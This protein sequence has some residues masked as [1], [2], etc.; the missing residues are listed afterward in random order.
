MRG[1]RRR[2]SASAPTSPIFRAGWKDSP[3]S[4]ETETWTASFVPQ[5]TYT[6]TT[7]SSKRVPS[8]CVVV[9][10]TATCG[11]RAPAGVSS[12]TIRGPSPARSTVRSRGII[13]DPGY[14]VES[15]S[16]P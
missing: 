10:E 11:W 9:R 7:V 5:T 3:P 2:P 15:P 13:A 14:T 1:P 16:T 8:T 12:A 4:F 6:S